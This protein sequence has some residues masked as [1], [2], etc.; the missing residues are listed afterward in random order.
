[1]NRS[2]RPVE[3]II[4]GYRV[5]PAG[6]GTDQTCCQNASYQDASSHDLSLRGA[7]PDSV[8]FD[9]GR[10]ELAATTGDAELA[11]S[12]VY[13]W[14]L[15][16]F[17]EGSNGRNALFRDCYLEK[18]GRPVA[19]WCQLSRPHFDGPL[20]RIVILLQIRGS[21]YAPDHGCNICGCAGESVKPRAAVR[22]T[23]HFL[24]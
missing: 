22:T 5:H 20:A 6:A 12:D 10:N 18:C 3:S 2:D 7:V 1:M 19:G 17:Y 8:N 23:A 14:Y 11:V 4:P 9:C 13:N 15:M 16:R 24:R 21:L